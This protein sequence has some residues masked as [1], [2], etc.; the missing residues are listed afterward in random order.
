MIPLTDPSADGPLL[1]ELME[2]GLLAPDV[3]QRID[4]AAGPRET[5][6]LN[7]YLLA[8]ADFVPEPAW[9]AWLIRRHGCHRFGPVGWHAEA[10]G[11]AQGELPAHGNLA[12][13]QAAGGA[14][15]VAV[16][17]PDR[18]KTGGAANPVWA[19]ATLREL[20]TV[21]TAWLAAAAGTM[22]EFRGQ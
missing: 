9:L 20:R 8:G 15:V 5:M 10:A 3:I 19:A 2:V 22:E 17:R 7:D 18:L 6:A 12:Y 4:L 16:L 14:P 1:A 21:R 13:R 11:W